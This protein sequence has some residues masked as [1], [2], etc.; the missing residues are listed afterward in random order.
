MS[1]I[2]AYALDYR[3]RTGSNLNII[4]K[5]KEVKPKELA[6]KLFAWWHY[7]PKETHKETLLVVV[8]WLAVLVMGAWCL[9]RGL[10]ALIG[11]V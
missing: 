5:E 11:G 3:I 9:S 7:T 10:P 6:N 4:G 2:V 1:R 8:L